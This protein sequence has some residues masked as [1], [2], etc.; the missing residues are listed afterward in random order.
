MPFDD[1]MTDVV[2]VYDEEGNLVKEKI[3][4]SVQGGKAVHTLNA[5]FKVDIGYFVERKLPSGITEKYKVLEPNYYGNFHGIPAHYQMKVVNVK[6]IPD[7]ANSSTVNTIHASGNARIYQNSTDNSTNSYTSY[8]YKEAIGKIKSDIMDL[9]L[10]PVDQALTTKAVSKLAEEVESG[11]LNK[12][13]MSAYI[14]LFPAAVSG[15]DSV[16]KLASMVGLN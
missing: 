12:D 16:I 4:A 3:K 11:S 2:S 10:D 8:E 9:D 6:A 1:L 15:L 7:P 14:S 13:K 5:D